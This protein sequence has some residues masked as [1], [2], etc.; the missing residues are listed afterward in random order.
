[1]DDSEWDD[2]DP[3][4]ATIPDPRHMSTLMFECRSP[5]WVAEIGRLLATGLDQP[6]W[7][8]DSADRPWPADK[9]DHIALALA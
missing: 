5:E 7:I 2:W 6:V 1:M 8:L 3:S 9:V 4:S